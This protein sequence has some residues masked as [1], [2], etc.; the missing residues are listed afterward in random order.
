MDRR[1]FIGWLGL[2][3]LA[4]PEAATAQPTGKVYRIGLLGNQPTSDMTGPQPLASNWSA[5]LRGMREL[6]Y[7]YGEH[8]VTEPRGGEGKPERIP[9]LAAE[10]VRLKVDV[11]VGAGTTLPA[12]KE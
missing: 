5:F 11:I 9:S 1:A 10:L 3:M 12:L 6:G 2:G 4:A 7:V 8:F